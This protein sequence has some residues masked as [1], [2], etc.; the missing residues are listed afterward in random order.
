MVGWCTNRATCEKS[1][2]A[3][4]DDKQEVFDD[5]NQRVRISMTNKKCLTTS[6]KG[7]ASCVLVAPRARP[8]TQQTQLFPQ[9]YDRIHDNTLR[10]FNYRRPAQGAAMPKSAARSGP[11]GD[12]ATRAPG[13]P[14]A[15]GIAQ[16]RVCAGHLRD[17]QRPPRR[18]FP[19]PPQKPACRRAA[20]RTPPPPRS[21]G[22][23]S[24]PAPRPSTSPPLPPAAPRC[25]QEDCHCRRPD[26]HSHRPQPLASPTAVPPEQP[27]M[28]R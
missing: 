15:L 18:R 2:P 6:I 4:L 19:Q 21:P 23:P 7:C 14:P 3:H 17:T 16:G 25:H 13:Y 8:Q 12:R 26:R 1:E 24:P 28:A 22:P 11:S 5:V 9:K 27:S 20:A 10:C